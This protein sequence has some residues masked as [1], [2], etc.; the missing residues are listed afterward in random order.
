[1]G[2][3]LARRVCLTISA[4]A[5]SVAMFA[6]VPA[7][8]APPFSGPAT[9]VSLNFEPTGLSFPT[10]LRLDT[11][12]SSDQTITAAHWGP[13]T[14][15]HHGGSYAFWC[16]GTSDVSGTTWSSRTPLRYPLATRGIVKLPV[17]V[18]ADYY[19]SRVSFWYL[20]PSLGG[21]DAGSNPSFVLSWRSQADEGDKTLYSAFPTVA[22]WTLVSRDISAGSAGFNAARRAAVVDLQF[23]DHVEINNGY[24]QQTPNGQ[25]PAI[26]DFSV[27]GFKYGPVRNLTVV[28]P[29]AGQIKLDWSAPYSA[30]GSSLVDTRSLTYR[31]FR[32]AVGSTGFPTE[33]TSDGSR[34]S[35]TTYT[36]NLSLTNG[37]QGI[38]YE[39]IIQAWDAG[40]GSGYGV[41]SNP[42]GLP[43]TTTLTA[44]SKPHTTVYTW[45]SFT[46][47]G[48]MVPA[49]SSAA[50][51]Y[52]RLSR[53]KVHFSLA[54]AY[55]QAN[56]T[57]YSGA[58]RLPASG[59][60]Y[61][62][63]LYLQGSAWRYSS[64][65]TTVTVSANVILSPHA[66]ATTA[67]HNKAFSVWGTVQP[68]HTSGTYLR[69][70]AY[71]YSGTKV[72]QS[73]SFPVTV[74]SV[75]QPAN[76]TKYTAS[77]K[78]PKA[79]AWKVRV[80]HGAHGVEGTTYGALSARITVK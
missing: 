48:T 54:S 35:A 4:A 39:H 51:V 30:V 79:G 7:F 60:W 76:T 20:M 2:L 52:L 8:A 67:T 58:V 59:T 22:T 50:K 24:S 28:S 15:L 66:P 77:V 70:Y 44:P 19:S 46:S 64:N 78:L 34:L 6:A 57:V 61:L 43:Y 74:T 31:V 1:M 16:A 42:I 13:V 63:A 73:V 14:S 71:R 5:L 47:T 26:D 41:Q 56:G 36:D 12:D 11:L 45:R 80:R 9:I 62:R 32:R 21:A 72:V 68:K 33:L 75:G 18:L 65:W 55:T 53:D 27:T 23:F 17:G 3:R 69:V 29:V 25:G 49:S 40:A 37:L 38:P 10:N